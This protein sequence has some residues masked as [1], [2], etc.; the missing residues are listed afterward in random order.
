MWAVLWEWGHEVK[1]KVMHRRPWPSLWPPR[2]HFIL[3]FFL[4]TCLSPRLL[5]QPH[6]ALRA[7][8]EAFPAACRRLKGWICHQS[9]RQEDSSTP[10]LDLAV[11]CRG[12]GAG[13]SP[14]SASTLPAKAFLPQ[15]SPQP[16]SKGS[17]RLAAERLLLTLSEGFFAVNTENR[18]G[19]EPEIADTSFPEKKSSHQPAS[20]PAGSLERADPEQAGSIHAEGNQGALKSPENLPCYHNT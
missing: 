15:G 3:L 7:L 13:G 19:K 2:G 4:G 12:M 8:H 14:K 16:C 6:H 5:Q 20:N 18:V 17:L 1:L 10:G 11:P 9:H